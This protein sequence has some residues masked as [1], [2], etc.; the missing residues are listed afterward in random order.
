MRVIRI[1]R[2]RDVQGLG[3]PPRVKGKGHEGK[4]QGK[5]FVTLDKPLTLLEGQGFFRGF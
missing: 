2:G 3:D 5:D 1:S 4:G